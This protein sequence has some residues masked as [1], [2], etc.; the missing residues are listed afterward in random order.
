MPIS[1]SCMSIWFCCMSKWSIWSVCLNSKIDSK[2]FKNYN[3]WLDLVK[4]TSSKIMSTHRIESNIPRECVCSH[5]AS[6]RFQWHNYGTLNKWYSCRL[7][8]IMIIT[9][10]WVFIF[11]QTWYITLLYY[12]VPSTKTTTMRAMTMK[13]RG[14]TSF[15]ELYKSIF[16]N[17]CEKY[18]LMRNN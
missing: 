13:T 2:I 15:L 8:V 4:E 10:I 6:G 16:M 11:N 7:I 5:L 17:L 12:L 18:F 9:G 3:V 1:I 14:V